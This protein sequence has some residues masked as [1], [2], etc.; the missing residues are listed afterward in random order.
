MKQQSSFD[1]YDTITTAIVN[2]IENDPGNFVMPW[3]RAPNLQMPINAVTGKTYRGIN[4]LSLWVGAQN[5]GFTNR[6]WATFKQWQEAGAKVR[7]GERGTPIVFYRQIEVDEPR[8]EESPDRRRIPFARAS[9]VFN[10]D[11]VDDYEAPPSPEPRPLFERLAH[12]EKVIAATRADIAYGGSRAFYRPSDDHI[13]MPEPGAFTG[14]PTSTAQESFYSTLLHELGH[15]TGA[16]KRLNRDDHKRQ[17]DEI[18]NFEEIIAEMTAAFLCTRLDITSVPRADHA[19]YIASYLKLLKEDKRA[20]FRA[21]TA[22]AA[23]ADFIMAF[24]EGEG[25]GI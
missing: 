23:A 5:S 12:V 20:I 22:S 17:F 21:A 1:I 2:A 11:Q 14:T 13:Q 7:K 18:Y 3:H 9:W 8:A 25:T 19:Q 6:G 4:V 24:S 15:W 16:A 10:V